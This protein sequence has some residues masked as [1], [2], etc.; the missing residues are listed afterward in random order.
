MKHIV[1]VG[2]NGQLGT[3]LKSLQWGEGYELTC[4]DR[5]KMDLLNYPN[6]EQRLVELKP[7]VII[8]ASAYTAVDKAETERAVSVA[9][10]VSAVDRMACAAK[11]L[12]AYLIHFSTDYVYDGL[13]SEARNEAE[14]PIPINAYGGDKL[15]GELSIAS[16]G[17]K[18]IVV[19]TSWVYSATHPCFLSSM[20][21]LATERSELRIVDDQWG[22]PTYNHDLALATKCMVDQIVSKDLF[23]TPG[24]NVFHICGQGETTWYRFCRAILI[25]AWAEEQY[26]SLLKMKLPDIFPIT[27]ENFP[28][29]AKRPLNSRLDQTKFQA[30]FNFEMPDWENSLDRCFAEL[31]GKKACN[32]ISRSS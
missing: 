9:V 31:V 18:A 8:N 12:D 22:A 21:R 1:L 2:S 11:L 30:T 4:L 16:A 23:V 25:R 13:G 32:H 14:I 19:R 15:A 3:A 20:I 27:T 5:S 10:N 29:P 24:S 7:D 26:S 28:L 17:A 6:I